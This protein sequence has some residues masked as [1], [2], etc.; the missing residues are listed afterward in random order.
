MA[1]LRPEIVISKEDAVFWL[2]TRGRWHNAYGPFR[3][4]RIITHFHESIRKDQ[5]GFFL[6][7]RHGSRTEKVYFRYEDTALFV[8]DV[9]LTQR[10]ELILNTGRKV[11]LEPRNLRVH[12]DWLYFQWGDE[13]VK[14][15]ERSLWKIL[16]HV[17]QEGEHYLFEIG[18]RT[19]PIPAG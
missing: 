13:R 14:F 3:N 15:N 9:N 8:F 12:N 2:D 17:E 7:Q 6:F 18:G 4:H 10:I 5:N 19:Y 11:W 1:D 16:E